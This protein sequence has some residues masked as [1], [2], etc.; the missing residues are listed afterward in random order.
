MK[1]CNELEQILRNIE[2]FIRFEV[3]MY[4]TVMGYNAVYF[5]EGPTI[6]RYNLPLSSGLESK[7][8]KKPTEAVSKPL[9]AFGLAYSSAPE[10]G[11]N[12]FL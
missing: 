8:S 7:P 12:I 9:L 10:D 5:G 6:R 4:M 11:D 3:L 2:K 1:H